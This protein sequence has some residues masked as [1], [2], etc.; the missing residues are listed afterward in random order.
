MTAG[1]DGFDAAPLAPAVKSHVVTHG[2]V[3]D[4]DLGADHVAGRD[5]CYQN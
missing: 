4:A 5:R 1:H 3:E 2:R